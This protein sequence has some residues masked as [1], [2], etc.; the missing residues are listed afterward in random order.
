[1]S[2]PTIDVKISLNALS[3]LIYVWE[4]DRN[5]RF[6]KGAFY[7]IKKINTE[8]YQ[9]KEKFISKRNGFFWQKEMEKN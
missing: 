9:I 2:E 4:M 1:M 5:Q 7:D 6:M 8:L 3:K